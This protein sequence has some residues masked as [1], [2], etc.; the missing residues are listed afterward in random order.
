MNKIDF[1]LGNTITIYNT[2][3]L[4]RYE[5][6]YENEYGI[7]AG[8]G[9]KLWSQYSSIS[10][11][12]N[13]DLLVLSN[14]INCSHLFISNIYNR[15]PKFETQGS[16]LAFERLP[17]FVQEQIIEYCDWIASQDGTDFALRMSQLKSF[18]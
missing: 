10:I 18:L 15:K 2:H 5:N 6:S 7:I 4:A 13:R 11:Y 14:R 12:F 17:T 9:H 3:I 8:Y 16:Q 1:V